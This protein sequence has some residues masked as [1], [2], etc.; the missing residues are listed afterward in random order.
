M[1]DDIVEH[2][3]PYMPSYKLSPPPTEEELK[4]FV[5]ANEDSINTPI[6]DRVTGAILRLCPFVMHVDDQ[7]LAHI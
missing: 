2:A 4:T 6:F 7:Y 3:A 1:E 5:P